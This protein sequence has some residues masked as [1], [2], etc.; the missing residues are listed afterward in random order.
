MGGV[1]CQDGGYTGG[2]IAC[3]ANCQYD[4]SGCVSGITG[5]TCNPAW[6]DSGFVDDC[7]CGC[8]II[9]PDCGGD[10]TVGACDYCGD[11]GSC[12]QG[13]LCPGF[14]DPADN[15]QCTSA[16][17]TCGDNL[18]EGGEWCDGPDLRLQDCT[19]IGLGF[20]G[21]TLAC[22]TSCQ[23][24]ISQ[25][26]DAVCG[27][28]VQEGF[29][30]CDGNDLQG[31]GCTDLGLG[32]G[33]GT[34]ACDASCQFN[35]SQCTMPI[36]GDNSTG[37]VEECDGTDMGIFATYPNCA[38]WGWTAGTITCTAGCEADFS[39]CTGGS[40]PAGWTC[41]DEWYGDGGCDCGCGVQD[42]DCAD[43]TVAVCVYCGEVGACTDLGAA[44]PANINPTDNSQCI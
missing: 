43:A 4:L 9:D 25:C 24:D 15:S 18:A 32:F 7:D 38:D 20:A 44:C 19:T 39:A 37:G 2:T 41:I 5:W 35:T 22:D 1:T 36:C 21:G 33:G 31:A 34:L 42:S 16:T 40:A 27:N 13:N 11:Y 26:T 3:D 23:F 30:H 10:V 12:D 6:Y 29:E 8:G 28:N 17:A 14:I